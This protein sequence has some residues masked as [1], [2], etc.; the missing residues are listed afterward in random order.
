MP[1][2]CPAHLALQAPPVLLLVCLAPYLQLMG[3]SGSLTAVMA[4]FCSAAIKLEWREVNSAWSLS[5]SFSFSSF[6]LSFS[7]L[8]TAKSSW[9]TFSYR[10]WALYGLIS[11]DTK[12]HAPM[13][14][15]LHHVQLYYLLQRF[16]LQACN[17]LVILVCG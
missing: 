17:G 11:V 13:V 8:S 15:T 6:S 2:P 16:V 3:Q 7:R 9:Y 4:Q 10:R 1:Q 12:R 5:L 14:L